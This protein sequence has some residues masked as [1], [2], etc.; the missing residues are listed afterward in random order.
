VKH[1]I[2][3][4]CQVDSVACSVCTA[5]ISFKY[6][7][8]TFKMKTRYLASLVI[9]CLG[10]AGLEGCGGGGGGSGP[11]T[12]GGNVVTATEVALEG[13]VSKGPATGAAVSIYAT[14]SNGKKSILLKKVTTGAGGAYSALIAPQA[15]PVLI[16]ADLNGAD[17]SDELTPGT[18]YKGKSGEK[19][20]AVLTLQSGTK[21]VANITPFSDMAAAMASSHGGTDTYNVS[22]VVAANQKIRD[23]TITDH[24]TVSPTGD[25]KIKLTAVAQFV[26]DIHAGDLAAGLSELRSACKFDTAKNGFVVTGVVSQKLATACT[27]ATCLTDNNFA[28]ATLAETAVAP[29]GSVS[30]LD[31]A[32][33]LFKDLRDTV[34]AYTNTGNT[35]EI[36]KA[37]DKLSL[38]VNSATGFVDDEMLAIIAGVRDG[39]KQYNDAKAGVSAFPV[40]SKGYDFSVFGQTATK[41][42]QGQLVNP[43]LQPLYAC[44][45][46]KATTLS[47]ASGETDIA[48]Y[49]YAGPTSAAAAVPL[50]DINAFA[51]FGVGTVGGLV[52]ASLDDANRRYHSITVLPQTDGTFKY[53]HQTRKINFDR[54]VQA[55]TNRDGQAM[56]GAGAFVKDTNNRVTSVNLAGNLSPGFKMLRTRTVAERAKFKQHSVNLAMAASYPAGATSNAVE[57]LAIS[58]NIQLLNVDGT[59][60]SSLTIANGSTL[61]AKTDVVR[62]TSSSYSYYGGMFC[63]TG[64]GYTQLGTAPNLFCSYSST[65]TSTVSELSA[66]NL[67]VVS[68]VPNAKF[69]GSVTAGAASFDKSGTQYRPTAGTFEGKIYEGDGAGGYRLLLAG[70]VSASAIDYQLFN[71]TASQSATNF[72]KTNVAFEGKVMLKDRPDAGLTLNVQN[73]DFNKTSMSGTFFWSGKSFNINGTKDDTNNTGALTFTNSDAV[74]FTLPRNGRN[75]PQDITKGGFK[76]GI[77]NI[78]TKR[79]D[80]IDGSF[81]QF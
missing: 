10:V 74:A 1:S 22:D 36:D 66:L 64:P 40:Y 26:K 30:T 46:A 45:L 20:L 28:S 70:R 6:K 50:A 52:G 37:G 51:C 4:A 54:T 80:F 24:L 59:T 67:S 77:I 21:T 5:H 63:P 58:G 25:F 39:Y 57:S 11:D 2:R 3:I 62:T 8:E 41:N 12:T 76:V 34:G 9:A 29:V 60:A 68:A 27:A 72:Y 71:E 32:K 13:V 75:L 56:F 79:I 65:Y 48:S 16:E 38:A 61:S 7:Q 23:L 47:T 18:T 42:T 33:A 53:V 73:Y 19:M 81:E 14:D 78:G 35:G 69:E 15:N 43:G 44:E 17:I 31:A 55:L 49:A